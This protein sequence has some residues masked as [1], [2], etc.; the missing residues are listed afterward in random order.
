M[1][2][3]AVLAEAAG[4]RTIRYGNLDNTRYHLYGY[5]HLLKLNLQQ[6]AANRRVMCFLNVR[7]VTRK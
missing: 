6:S 3:L 1:R 5:Y 2:E 4:G 7:R